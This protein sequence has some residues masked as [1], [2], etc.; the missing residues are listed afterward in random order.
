MLPVDY[1]A[2]CEED[3]KPIP[4]ADCRNYFGEVVGS[5][6]AGDYLTLLTTAAVD[7]ANETLKTLK[8][9]KGD[10]VLA[11]ED[12]E[13]FDKVI[14]YFIE[15]VD[16]KLEQVCVQAIEYYD[17]HNYRTVVLSDD[18]GCRQEYTILNDSILERELNQAIES[19]EYSGEL[20]QGVKVSETEKYIIYDSCWQND[21]E[22]YSI[23]VKS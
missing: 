3:I 8:F 6:Q 20:Y 11:Y 5:S 21:F 15:G 2:V 22:A 12:E 1:L 7:A 18:Y 9:Q 16:F 14:D 13:L 17:G 4:L 19:S 23:S 10:N